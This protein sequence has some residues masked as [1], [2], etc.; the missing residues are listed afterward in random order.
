[1]KRATPASSLARRLR[2]V[3]ANQPESWSHVGRDAR[4]TLHGMIRYPAMMVP[5]M[6][7]DILD[8]VLEEADTD[9]AVLDPFVGSG[10]T[11]TEALLR[12]LDFTGID[13]NPLAVL[14]CEAKAAI[15]SGVSLHSAATVVLQYLAEDIDETVDVEFRGLE[16]WF[17]PDAA[18]HFSRLR[19]SIQQ[20]PDAGARKVMWVLF[21]DTVR[22]CS[23]SRTSTYKLHIRPEGSS[24]DG[25]RINSTFRAN[26]REVLGRA[27]DYLAAIKDRKRRPKIRI[28]CSDI[29]KARVAQSRR[30]HDVLVTSPPYG[31]NQTTIPYGQFSYL[32][33]NWIPEQD[34]PKGWN[35]S[36]ASNSNS[37]DAA[38]L[39]GSVRGFDHSEIVT[40]SPTF[41]KF[42]AEARRAG[43]EHSVRKVSAFMA[44]Y[45][46]AL[47]RLSPKSTGGAHW[48]MTTGNRRAAG[49]VVPFDKINEDIVRYMEG[50]CVA[51]IKRNLPVK[52]MPSRNSIGAMITTE[53]TLV[54]EFA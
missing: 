53:T 10:T 43:K 9:C 37:I 13:I 51:S 31:D 3:E 54:A 42:L 52:R 6:Q 32:A 5:R 15:D 25:S 1:M 35:T 33:L 8:M 18:I 22:L 39:G 36:L 16:K 20:V 49:L 41:K 26:L 45:F 30:R 24:V 14:V 11:M 44:D 48:I 23:N 19:R 38:S 4:P 7:G 28:V 27:R 40:A 34:L 29:L 50:V 2:A 46:S 47:Q 12:G 17:S 21:A